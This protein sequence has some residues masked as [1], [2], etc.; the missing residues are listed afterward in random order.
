MS[1]RRL[2]KHSALTFFFQ[3]NFSKLFIFYR[4]FIV[5]TH[6]NAFLNGATRVNTTSVRVYY[7][8]YINAICIYTHVFDVSEM[9]RRAELGEKFRGHGG[10]SE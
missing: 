2:V 3:E 1:L 4:G 9:T 8:I 6:V 7:Y 5:K 10:K